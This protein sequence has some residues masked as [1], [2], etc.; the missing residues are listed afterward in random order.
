MSTT[1]VNPKNAVEPP[2]DQLGTDITTQSASEIVNTIRQQF[3]EGAT[4]VVIH[5]HD[6]RTG[7]LTPGQPSSKP[8]P[9]TWSPPTRTT[10]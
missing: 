10:R 5:D 1:N 9:T 8:T 6:G 3:V 2:A 4:A 7:R